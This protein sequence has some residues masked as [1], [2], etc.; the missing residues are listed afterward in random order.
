MKVLE[1]AHVGDEKEVYELYRQTTEHIHAQEGHAVPVPAVQDFAFLT[2]LDHALT[3]RWQGGER[4]LQKGDT[5]YLPTSCPACE[6][7]GTG[8]AAVSMPK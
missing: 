4:V 3:L 6:V 2:A 5:V 7:V 8:R 1:K